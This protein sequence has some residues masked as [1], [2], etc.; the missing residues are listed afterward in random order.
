MK[1]SLSSLE[2]SSNL[3]M[4]KINTID[5]PVIVV[6]NN[7]CCSILKLLNF[8]ELIVTTLTPH[9]ATIVKY[10]LNGTVI[11]CT[12]GISWKYKSQT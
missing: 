6:Q 1:N 9:S 2:V 7:V 4:D 5:L 8:L 3:M 10:R 11:H 12:K